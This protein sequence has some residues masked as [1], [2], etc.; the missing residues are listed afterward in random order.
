CKSEAKQSRKIIQCM[1]LWEEVTLLDCFEQSSRNDVKRQ[2]CL[3]TFQ[4]CVN[5]DMQPA[6]PS[7]QARGEAIQRNTT[8]HESVGRG[9]VTG[10]LRAKGPRNDVKRQACLLTLPLP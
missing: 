2:A 7:L 8:T 9:N 4:L 3:L 1:N 5:A 6:F 10:L